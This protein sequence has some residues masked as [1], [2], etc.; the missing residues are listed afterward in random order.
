MSFSFNKTNALNNLSS[1]MQGFIE[2]I[3]KTF[4]TIADYAYY[5]FGW[6][7]SIARRFAI[8]LLPIF[9][10][11]IILIIYAFANAIYQYSVGFLENE[12]RSTGRKFSSL[13][14]FFTAPF[15]SLLYIV[16]GTIISVL[17]QAIDGLLIAIETVI[18]G[19]IEAI[20]ALKEEFMKIINA[21]GRFAT[22]AGDFIAG[23]AEEAFD[24]LKD[25]AEDLL[26]EVG[27]NDKMLQQRKEEFE[28]FMD[29]TMV[30]FGNDVKDVTEKGFNE[31][32]DGMDEGL[33]EIGIDSGKIAKDFIKEMDE[34]FTAF[35]D[36]TDNFFSKKIPDAMV[37][38]GNEIGDAAEI[39]AKW[40]KDTYDSH[41]KDFGEMLERDF[42]K[43]FKI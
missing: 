15:Q 4:Q 30:N 24:F 10:L 7:R 38:A 35:D 1:S 33:K 8:L 22:E 3:R 31:F 2:N 32:A 41:L 14:L 36:L 12:G 21:A 20:N 39:K 23:N 9:I 29:T 6:L 5:I 37:I 34:K 26:E 25:G 13:F 42:K 19:L 17:S 43:K 28:N 40:I 27:I 16:L 11:N 18:N